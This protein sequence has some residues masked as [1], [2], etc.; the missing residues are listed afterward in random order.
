MAEITTVTFDLWQ[1]L[2][3]D[4]RNLGEARALVRLEG[5]QSALSTRGKDFSIRHI[6]EAYN[7][8]FVQCRDIRDSGL[9]V[10]FI[11][12]VSIFMND[13]DAGLTYSLGQGVVDDIAQA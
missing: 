7:S 5:A 3:L 2:L 11:E 12:Q 6:R 10:D 4:E 9:D 13:I 8:C 1:T